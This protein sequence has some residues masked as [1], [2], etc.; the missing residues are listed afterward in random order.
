MEIIKPSEKYLDEYLNA[1]KESYDNNI[2][3]WMPVELDNFDGWKARALQ[4]Y[5]MLESGNGL[6]E[7]VP[8]MITYWCVENHKFIGEI[9]IRPYLSLEEAKKVGHI[10]Y[11]VR[12]SMWNKGFGTKLLKFS[13]DK[14]REKNVSPIYIACHVDN[15]GSNRVR[16]KVGFEF[17]E[18]RCLGEEKENLYILH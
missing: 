4:L 14:L 8:R 6:P 17:V 11:A 16:Q 15:L 3:E 9:Q 1:C 2:K 13:V 12:Y 10:G 7:G 5:E 18:T